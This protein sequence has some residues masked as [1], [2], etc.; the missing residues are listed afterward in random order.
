MQHAV[1]T[2]QPETMSAEFK[3]LYDT[4]AF[5]NVTKIGDGIGLGDSER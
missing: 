3:L 4:Y 1:I 5:T 2:N